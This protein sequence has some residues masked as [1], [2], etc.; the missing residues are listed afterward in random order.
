MTSHYTSVRRLDESDRGLLRHWP[1]RKYPPALCRFGIGLD[2]TIGGLAG[3]TGD[4]ARKHAVHIFSSGFQMLVCK[5]C[6]LYVATLQNKHVQ[7]LIDVSKHFDDITLQEH[8]RA[9]VFKGRRVPL[10]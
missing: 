4:R 7:A 9:L 5:R 2:S 1:P 6:L 8:W 10:K 3:T